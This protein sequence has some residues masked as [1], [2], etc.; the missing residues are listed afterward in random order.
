MFVQC[1]LTTSLP[2]L[3]RIGSTDRLDEQ[4]PG[5]RITTFHGS[6]RTTGDATSYFVHVL[7]RVV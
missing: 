6:Q 5:I 7:L 3:S 2:A 1:V 4:K